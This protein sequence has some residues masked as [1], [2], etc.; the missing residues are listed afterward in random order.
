MGTPMAINLRVGLPRSVP[1]YVYDANPDVYPSLVEGVKERMQSKGVEISNIE[2]SRWIVI[3]ANAKEVA[4][5]SVR[6]RI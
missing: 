5:K 3:C 1:L 4:E 6:T 2:T